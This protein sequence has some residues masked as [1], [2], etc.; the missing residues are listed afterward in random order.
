ML[1][2][3]SRL[4]NYILKDRIKAFYWL[5]NTCISKLLYI[6]AYENRTKKW[7]K[8]ITLGILNVL[9]T[10]GIFPHFLYSRK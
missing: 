5:K 9:K 8:T 10:L 6:F 3:L 2:M 1:K 4:Y 7:H